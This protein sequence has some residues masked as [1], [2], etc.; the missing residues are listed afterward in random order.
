M[1]I[2]PV[3][4]I[5][6]LVNAA[7]PGIAI[8][9]LAV[10]PRQLPFH[11]GVQYFELERTSRFWDDLKT[12]GGMAVHVAGEFPGLVLECWAIKAPQV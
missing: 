12:S 10:A 8:R 3:E 7:L 9:P 1:K 4:Q 6:N 11:P 2:G 5:R